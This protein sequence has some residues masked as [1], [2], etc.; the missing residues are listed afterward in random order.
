MTASYSPHSWGLWG[1]LHTWLP[2]HWTHEIKSSLLVTCSQPWGG[3][4]CMPCRATWGLHL[5]TKW[6]SSGCE[7][8][9][10]WYQ[11]SKVPYGS[12]RR[13]WLAC[14]SNSVGWRATETFYSGISR[15][16]AFWKRGSFDYRTLSAGAEWGGELA[17]RPFETFQFYH[18][19]RQHIIWGLNFRPYTTVRSMWYGYFLSV[20]G[21]LLILLMAC[22]KRSF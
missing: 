19:S 6:T 4:H 8:Q 12:Y 11:E 20:H 2:Q 18:L 9:A 14:L 22:S 13:M 5:G 1:W 17:I 16:Y 7:S 10:L 15:P 21:L 3:G